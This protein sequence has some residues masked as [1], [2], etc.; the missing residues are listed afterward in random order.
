MTS[1]K[2]KILAL[3]EG[4]RGQALSGTDIAEKLRLSRSAVWKSIEELRKE[5]Y[6]I[7]AVTNKGYSLS[8]DSDILSAEGLLLWARDPSITPNKI[9]VFKS[10]GSTNQ[11]AKKM[12][13][14]GAG[15][16]TIVLAEEQT[17]GRGRLGR[18]FFSPTGTGLYM[19]VLLRPR[20]TAEE[21]ALI[22]TAAAVAVCRAISQ[23]LKI[24]AGIKWVNDIFVGDR[25]VCGI[26]TEAMSD[27]QTGVVETLI[28]GIGINVTTKPD[29]F[30]EDIQNTA[31]SLLRGQSTVLR[32]RLAAAILDE[33]L[34]LLPSL[35]SKELMDE[36]KTRS[37]IIGKQITVYRGKEVYDAKALDIDC[38]GA[39]IIEKAD[40]SRET[41]RSGEVSIRPHRV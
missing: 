41:L 6:G 36:Y 5:G 37:F 13:V 19:S 38:K 14:A 7:H 22:T 25:K 3:L 24:E 21:A 8:E 34:R 17:E 40:R 39:L 2:S 27:I 1:T 35:G 29:H 32:N 20:G 30:P 28:L 33:L 4:N 18:S 10:I 15:H 23:V 12:A 31:G 16:G 11:E 9:H 26:L